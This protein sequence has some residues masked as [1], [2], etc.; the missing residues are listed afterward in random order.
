MDKGQLESMDYKDLQALA[1]DMGVSAAGKAED[2]MARIKA[3]VVDLPEGELTEEEQAAFEA[4]Q[5][6][7]GAGQQEGLVTVKAITRFLDRRLNQ[8]K[9]EGETYRVTLERA[10]ELEAAGVAEVRQ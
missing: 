4:G 2:I 9:D 5:R 8:I 6:E 7:Q 3:A 10:A 1:K